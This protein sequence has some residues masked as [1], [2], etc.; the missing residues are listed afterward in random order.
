MLD[1]LA[2]PARRARVPATRRISPV[3]S[4]DSETVVEPSP[5]TPT[6][7]PKLTSDG[8]P[9]TWNVRSKLLTASRVGRRPAPSS[10]SAL[11]EPSANA[12]V[13]PASSPSDGREC[14]LAEMRGP[15]TPASV[16]STDVGEAVEVL[17]AV[18]QVEVPAGTG[19]AA[20]A[21]G[22]LAREQ[23]RPRVRGADAHIDQRGHAARPQSTRRMVDFA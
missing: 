3:D 12:P 17:R 2:V 13:K 4:L 20:G 15:T 21:D 9:S 1:R 5:L 7:P 23:D 10:A 8:T 18:V 11:A 16:V 22:R 14:W 19:G 6:A